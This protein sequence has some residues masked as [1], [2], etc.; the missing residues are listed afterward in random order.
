MVDFSGGGGGGGTQQSS[1]KTFFKG[2]VKQGRGR[3]SWDNI[4]V[5][6]F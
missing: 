4:A 6:D 2:N 5:S 1:G 3:G